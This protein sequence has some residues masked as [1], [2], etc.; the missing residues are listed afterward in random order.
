MA[1]PHSPSGATTESR[2][3]PSDVEPPG[4]P[5]WLKVSGLVV[6]VLLALVLVVSLIAGGDHGPGRHASP[7]TGSAQ[8]GAVWHAPDA[9]FGVPNGSTEW[10]PS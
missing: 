1:E 10:A 6:V 2:P 9:S 5:R 8:V 7:L 4:M 3:D